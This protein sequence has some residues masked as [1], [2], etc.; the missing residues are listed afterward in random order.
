[1]IRKIVSNAINMASVCNAIK[2]I[3][4]IQ[5]INVNF[6]RV[7]V[8]FVIRMEPARNVPKIEF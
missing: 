7:S 8:V 6:V 1:M 4:T 5:S 3:I 2:A